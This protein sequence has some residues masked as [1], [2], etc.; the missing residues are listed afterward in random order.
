M[1][2][3]SGERSETTERAGVEVREA[4]H[5]D[6]DD[7]AAFTQNTWPERDGGD[8]IPDVYHDWIEG[9]DKHTAVAVADG[10]V[11]GLAQTV[12]LSEWE[13]WNQGL[14]V[15]PEFR[16]RG[17]SVAVTESLFEWARQRG[18]T[19]ARNMVFSWN[20]AG[21]GQS[22]ATGYDP[23][24]EFRW[25]H[26][27]PTDADDPDDAPASSGSSVSGSSSADFEVTSDP[28]AAWR[29][30]TDSEARDRLRGLALDPEESWALSELTLGDLRAAADDGGLFVVQGDGT[31]GFA[32]RI[33]EYER[34]SDEEAGETEQWVEYGVGAWADAESADALFDAVA[35]DAAELGADRTRVLIPE[36]PRFVSDAA[37]CRVEVADEPDFVLGADLTA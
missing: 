17:V 19:V 22:R 23:V 32:H 36:S 33:R 5:D 11:A 37:L 6:Y 12:L 18:A 28:R 30:W 3:A 34:E 24:T 27:D 14:R 20:V 10:E 15:N 26:P 13:A 35:R 4:R 1:T 21:L 31:R 29:Y 25:A 2:G 9:E 16:G 8:Y 7:V